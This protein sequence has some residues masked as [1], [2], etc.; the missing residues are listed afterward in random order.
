MGLQTINIGSVP[1]DGTGDPLRTAL[2]KVN[3]NFVTVELGMGDVD[4]NGIVVASPKKLYFNKTL[5]RMWL[6]ET[7]EETNTGWE[8]WI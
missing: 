8:Q 6:K 5:K 1:N 3:T 4:P 7:G 2:Q